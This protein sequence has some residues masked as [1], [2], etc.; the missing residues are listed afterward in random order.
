M[1][2]VRMETKAVIESGGPQLSGEEIT[3]GIGVHCVH[4]DKVRKFYAFLDLVGVLHHQS[5]SVL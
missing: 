1:V 3:A 4:M 2:S 5:S